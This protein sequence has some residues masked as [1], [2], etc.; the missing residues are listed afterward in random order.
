MVTR[1]DGI[2]SIAQIARGLE[3]S[4]FDV[5]KLVYGLIT[6]DLVALRRNNHEEAVANGHKG[7]LELASQIREEAEKYLGESGQKSIEK[8][9]RA[10]VD[11]IQNGEGSAAVRA[12]ADELE[13][14]TSLLRGLSASDQ[15]RARIAKLISDSS[16]TPQ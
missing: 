2:K 5:A 14:T 3:V 12:M 7:L 13:K 15:L 9:Y 11:G 16:L 8:Y 6:S 4:P 1:I 10:A